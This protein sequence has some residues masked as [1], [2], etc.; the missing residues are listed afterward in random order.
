[1]ICASSLYLRA[2]SAAAMGV[3]VGSLMQSQVTRPE[4]RKMTNA[5]M[6][7]IAPI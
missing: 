3:S 2:Y 1:M 6:D 5:T 4:R 7:L